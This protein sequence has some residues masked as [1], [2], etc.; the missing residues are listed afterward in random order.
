MVDNDPLAL[1]LLTAAVSKIPSCTLMW[2]CEHGTTA[3]QRC[4]SA[5]SACPDVLIVDMSLDDMT[6]DQVC[7]AVRRENA[8]I[9]VIGITA[10]TVGRYRRRMIHAGAQALIPKDRLHD[11]LAPAI[12]QVTAGRPFDP[13]AAHGD[14]TETFLTP[15]QAHAA[16]LAEHP[17]HPESPEH[18]EH[19][20]PSD[21][22]RQ[23]VALSQR[24][25]ETLAAYAQGLST[26]EIASRMHV[27]ESA[28]YSYQSR[29]IRKLNARNVIQA[30]V[31]AVRRGLL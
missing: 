17:N 24:E 1:R 22:E 27:T 3:I 21:E 10:Y 31:T 14:A 25:H 16:L 20:A 15:H 29:A 8:D 11:A 13:D 6:G 9:A 2:V 12:A 30:A 4:L 7:A 28:V 19:P 23:T 18:P 26:R 5:V